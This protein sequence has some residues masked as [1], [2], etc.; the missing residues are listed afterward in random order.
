[1]PPADTATTT[2]PELHEFGDVPSGFSPIAKSHPERL[3]GR[4]PSQ[5][6]TYLKNFAGSA[7]KTTTGNGAMIWR[8]G[9]EILIQRPG[10]GGT[11]FEADSAKAA[12]RYLQKFIMENGGVAL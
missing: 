9:T 3:A 2:V 7:T 10:S 11:Y 12:L 6:A 8:R 4:S 5:M 1:M